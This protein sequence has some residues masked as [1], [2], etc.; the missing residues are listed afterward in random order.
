M[1]KIIADG[2]TKALLLAKHEA[3]VGMTSLKDQKHYLAS[4]KQEKDLKEAIQ[5][6]Q[7]N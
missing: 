4:V 1:S 5:W 2:L 3:F 6:R 7:V